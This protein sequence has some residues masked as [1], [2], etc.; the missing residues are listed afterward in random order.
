MITLKE[1]LAMNPS[2]RELLEKSTRAPF[3]L[4]EIAYCLEMLSASSGDVS[5]L[6]AL[7]GNRIRLNF[8]TF[9][10]CLCVNSLVSVSDQEQRQ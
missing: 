7:H 1:S 3:I 4:R 5:Q 8:R 9:P 10:V 2:T 6:A